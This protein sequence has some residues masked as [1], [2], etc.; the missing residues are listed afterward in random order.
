[1]RKTA[2]LD[3]AYFDGLY[4]EKPDPWDF[5]T[6]DYEAR[7][8][9]ATI[10]AL[11]AERA[12]WALE[13]G[14]SIGILTRRLAARCDTLVATEVSQAALDQARARCADLTNIEFRLVGGAADGF[15][16]A[17]DLIVL[18]EVVY[19]WDDADLD[20]VA[21]GIRTTLAPGGRLLLVHYTL[22]TD[23]P[24]SGD[25]AVAALGARLDG[26]VTAEVSRRAEA[27]RLDLWR[28]PER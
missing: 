25:D 19:Y 22:E 7:K 3:A 14:C 10:E 18:S 2:S 1:M 12:M 16:D 15:D 27:Y 8:Y 9:D 5:E 6:S 11:G 20:A 4:A 13:V 26:F 23:Y 17:Y 24:K 21:A 28:R